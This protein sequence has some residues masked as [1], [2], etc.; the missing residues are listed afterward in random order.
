MSTVRPKRNIIKKKY[1]ISDG[2]PW[3]EERLVRKVLFL[4][5]RE[6]RDRHRATHKHSIKH[7]RV[8]KRTSKNTLLHAPRK[9][10]KQLITNA[11]QKPVFIRA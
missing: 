2:M 3:C 11:L 1:D 8:P 10:Q 9:A 6:F 7:T 5:L 4:S